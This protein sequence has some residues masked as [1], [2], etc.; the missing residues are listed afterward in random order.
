M[1][2]NILL[3]EGAPVNRDAGNGEYIE[4]VLLGSN[5]H[6]CIVLQFPTHC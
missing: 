2:N 1:Q 4:N 5:E 6:I 3:A